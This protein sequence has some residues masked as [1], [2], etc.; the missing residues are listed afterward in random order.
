MRILVVED[1]IK[2]GNHLRKGLNEAGFTV[3]LARNGLDGQHLAVTG[4]FDV[5]ILDLPT[6]AASLSRV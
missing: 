5:I 3:A 1:E 4:P 2:T 6:L